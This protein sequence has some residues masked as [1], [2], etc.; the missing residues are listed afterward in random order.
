MRLLCFKNRFLIVLLFFN[1]SLMAESFKSAIVYYADKK[2]YEILGS[3][4]IVI[5][6]PDN[7]DTSN[8]GFRKYRDKIFAYVSMCEVGKD[9]KYFK[10]I[11]KNWILSENR[12]WKSK[13]LDISDKGYR[14]FLIKTVIK[15]LIDKG[16]RNIFFDTVD[17][18]MALKV[19]NKKRYEDGIVSL[20]REIK[21]RYPFVKII[22]NRGF[23]VINRAHSFIDGV[24]FESL[25]FGLDFR[26][27]SYKKVSKK[28]REWLLSKVK[29][30][31]SY[32]LFAICVDYLPF[33]DKRAKKVA[34][35]IFKLGVIPYIGDKD[36]KRIGVSSI[37]PIKR[38]VLVLYNSFAKKKEH[39]LAFHFAPILEYF[40]YI[41]VF[42]KEKDLKNIFLDRYEA[43]FAYFRKP[44]KNP[45][46]YGKFIKKADSLGVKSV[47]FG[48][49]ASITLPSSLKKRVF[50]YE[51]EP[52]Y[53]IDKY[54]NFRFDPFRLF[55]KILPHSFPVPDP[56]TK[57]GKRAAFAYV[58]CKGIDEFCEFERKRAFFALKEH[59]L[60][61]YIKRIPHTLC[62]LEGFKRPFK[63]VEINVEMKKGF[64]R[65]TNLYPFYTLLSPIGVER[66]EGFDIYLPISDEIY[67]TNWWRGPFWGYMKVIQTF[68]LTEY[69]RRLKPIA[70]NY[71]YLSATKKASLK[72]LRDVYRWVLKRD[73]YP[74]FASEYKKRALDFYYIAI[75]LKDRSFKIEGADVLRTFRLPE[76]FILDRRNSLNIK[77]IDRVRDNLYLE[78]SDKEAEIVKR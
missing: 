24:L 18:Y 56:S 58:G 48:K 11:K 42:V 16:Y 10:K 6:E 63:D 26:D 50:V 71:N 30:I 76:D 27:L 51:K 13:I 72:A 52:F 17:S 39:S 49:N 61:R 54:Y 20:L 25:F 69:P 43:V 9:R 33:G 28:D 60:K 37:S 7:T 44:L 59:I 55:E 65:L 75:S 5:L 68:K 34:D 70:I 78:I 21:N 74:M 35:E 77:R 12:V 2:P 46:L 4:D 47:L 1:L 3:F 64:T 36:L 45:V 66:G 32:D 19:K 41:P 14:D 67:Y 38:R 8:Y 40:G 29:E 53:K 31:K 23:E 15:D 57:E 22:L 62:I 73:F